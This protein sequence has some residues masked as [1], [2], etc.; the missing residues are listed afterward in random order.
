MWDKVCYEGMH[1]TP[2]ITGNLWIWELFV[3]TWYFLEIK[4][5]KAQIDKIYVRN[6]EF[7]SELKS[8]HQYSYYLYLAELE[9]VFLFLEY[10]TTLERGGKI[11]HILSRENQEK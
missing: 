6:L 10:H 5:G 8:N 11:L 4:N 3:L 2:S 7:W 9:R 1:P